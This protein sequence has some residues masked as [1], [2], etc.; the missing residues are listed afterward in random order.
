MSEDISYVSDVNGDSFLEGGVQFYKGFHEGKEADFI[1]IP[2][3]GDKTLIIDTLVEPSHKRRF[4]RQWAAYEGMQN[5]TGTPIS[6]WSEV[7]E[8]LRN[9][10]MYQG[11]RFIEQIAAAPESAFVRMMGGL[12]WRTKAQ[13]FLNRGKVD[14]EE[15]IKKQAD[16]IAEMQEQ[17]K[18]MM[19]R[20]GA[21]PKKRGPKSKDEVIEE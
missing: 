18:Q 6:E 13:A 16:Q 15:M 2:V 5:M 4:A 3:P 12:Q 9:E 21:E 8:G 1:K 17:M 10:F 7:P 19:D 11:F 14:A 20:M